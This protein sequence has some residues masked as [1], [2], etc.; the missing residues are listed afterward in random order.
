MTKT[1]FDAKLS[2]LNKKVNSNKRKHLLVENEFK[3]LKTFDVSYFIGKSHFEEDGTQNYLVFHPLNKYFKIITNKKYISSWK[4]RGLSDETIKP[5]ATM[6]KNIGKGPTQGLGEHSLTA[7]KMHSVNFTDNGDK[8]C[9]SLHYN[10]VNSYSFVN[11]KEIIKFEAKDSE[12]VAIPLCLGNISKDWSVDN[13]KD[14]GLNG[15][16]YGFSVDYDDATAVDDIK[17]IHKYLMKR[18]NIV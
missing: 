14:T 3:K 4:S 9:L 7:E 13:T 10:G 8:Y 16:V 5:P 1:D 6:E 12:I 11:G 15:Y 18:N 17:D 2:S